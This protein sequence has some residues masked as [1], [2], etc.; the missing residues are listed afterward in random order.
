M[1]HTP[2]PKSS[3]VGRPYSAAWR[4]ASRREGLAALARAKA[5]DEFWRQRR[6]E[7]KAGIG[8]KPS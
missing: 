6:A 5:R 7:A 3:Q 1:P 4:R 8:E 2:K